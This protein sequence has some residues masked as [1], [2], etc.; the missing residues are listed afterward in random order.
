MRIQF[1]SF[2]KNTNKYC[3][4]LKDSGGNNE[5]R[6]DTIVVVDVP[7]DPTSNQTFLKRI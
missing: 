4:A 7:N 3:V 5:V 6:K 1:Q 2:S